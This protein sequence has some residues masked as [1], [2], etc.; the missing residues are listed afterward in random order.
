MLVTAI[1]DSNGVPCQLLSISRDITVR[2]DAQRERERIMQELQRSNRELSQFSHMVA[3]DLQTPV[4]TVQ[5]FTE[6]LSE[7]QK[8]EGAGESIQ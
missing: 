4:R 7:K 2:R 5:I 1:P 8:G 3:H 6:L